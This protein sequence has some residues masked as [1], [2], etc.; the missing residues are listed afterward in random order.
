MQYLDQKQTL[1]FA[2][3]ESFTFIIWVHNGKYYSIQTHFMD[4]PTCSM[5]IWENKQEMINDVVWDNM[6]IEA[7]TDETLKQEVEFKEL[8]SDAEYTKRKEQYYYELEQRKKN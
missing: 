4:Y 5:C 2:H 8:A 1:C 3:D 7:I 6:L